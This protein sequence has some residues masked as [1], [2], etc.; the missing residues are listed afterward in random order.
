[1]AD[2][3]R[4]TKIA[5]GVL[6]AF[7][8]YL[9]A[10]WAAESY[11]MVGGEKPHGEE[12]EVVRGYVLL[13]EQEDA[14]A[15]Q[16]AE[17]E[18]SLTELLLAADVGRGERAF[19]KCQACHKREPGANASGPTL[20][21][22]VG[23]DIASVE[24]FG[25]SA[26]LEAV[27]GAWTPEALDAWLENPKAF[28]PGNKMTFKG[29]AKPTDRANL[30]AYLATLGGDGLNLDDAAVEPAPA[31]QA[32][33]APAT[34]PAEA[35]SAAGGEDGSGDAPASAPESSPESPPADS[36]GPEA[37]PTGAPAGD[38]GDEASAAPAGAAAPAA[39]Q[40]AMAGDPVAGERVYKK[41]KACH[42]VEAGINKVGPSLFAIVGQDV[43]AAEGFR[44]SDA[45]RAAGGA[46]SPERLDAFLAA[47][48]AYIPGTRMSFAGLR[49]QEDRR[50]VIAYLATLDD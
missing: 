48:K 6:S 13:A 7:L 20:Y 29:L 11:F 28:A 8:I 3:L 39:T 4:N 24:G 14:G 37:E 47:P 43:A 5:G 15:P 2:T 50:N 25:Y 10:N 21:A 12:E 26:A 38:A 35:P 41:C 23:A 30:I 49:K 42:A 16:E 9:L 19:A 36:G 46:W 32:G 22:I 18:V 1:M 33:D 44:Y 34:G 27:E 17:P 31:P 40:L 45:M